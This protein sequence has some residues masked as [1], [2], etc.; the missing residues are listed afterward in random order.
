[1]SAFDYFPDNEEYPWFNGFPIQSYIKY[2]NY[3]N[4]PI[5]PLSTGRMDIIVVNDCGYS[6]LT[7]D[8]K[9]TNNPYDNSTDKFYEWEEVSLS[10]VNVI[11]VYELSGEIISCEE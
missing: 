1:M 4:F 5:E 10:G 7:N 3:I 9:L 8:M 2:D 6:I 11:S